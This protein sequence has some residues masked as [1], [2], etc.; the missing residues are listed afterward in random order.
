MAVS[1]HL[2]LI[3]ANFW[4]HNTTCALE[5]ISWN[6]RIIRYLF[7]VKRCIKNSWQ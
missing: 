1:L 6:L 5:N 3:N 7:S 4:L 2:G